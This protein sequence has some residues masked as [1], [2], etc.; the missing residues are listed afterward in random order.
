MKV[1]LPQLRRFL[2]ARHG[3]LGARRFKGPEGL[4]QYV[5]Q[6]GCIQFDPVD[7]CGKSHELALLARVEGFSHAMLNTLLY[8][9]RQ[10]IDFFDKNMCIMPREDWPCLEHIRSWYRQQS[11][12]ADKVE[13]VR[14][15]VLRTVHERGHVSAAELGLEGRADWYWSGSSLSR[16]ALETLYFRGDL[17]IHHKQGSIKSYALASDL[18][19]TELYASPCPFAADEERMRWQILRRIGA[20]GA[21][22]NSHSDAWLGVDGMKAA[23]RNRIFAALEAEGAIL[24]I[25]AEG[26][27]KLLYIKAEEAETLAAAAAPSTAAKRVRLLAPLDCLMWDRKLIEAVF[28][29]FYRWEIYTPAEKRQYSYYVLPVIYGE[30]FAGRIEPVLDRKSAVLTVRHFWPEKGFRETDAFRRELEK[31]LAYL[32]CFHGV[33]EVRWE[34]DR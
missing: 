5:R 25:E 7:V 8:E 28:G 29:F 2:L 13:A 19:P 14:E 30:R 9:Q 33:Q 11:R 20:V 1:S 16:V 23:Q 18:L 4:M 3:L 26:L 32:A 12:S 27:S 31:E 21:L 6:C 17:V 24:P 15:Q 22:P 10:L 34:Q